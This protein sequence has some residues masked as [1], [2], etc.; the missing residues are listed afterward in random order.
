MRRV[1]SFVVLIIGAFILVCGVLLMKRAEKAADAEDIPLFETVE[2]GVAT[3]KEPSFQDLGITSINLNIL[4]ADVTIIGGTSDSYVEFVNF[5]PNL[6]VYSVSGKSINISELKDIN[7]L[8]E[9]WENGLAFKGMRN[10]MRQLLGYYKSRTADKK[11][12]IYLGTGLETLNL[13][14]IK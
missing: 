4:N 3:V 6:F 13:V 1:R 2:N 9:F 7:S 12:N 5:N 11:I 14:D 8:F 10:I